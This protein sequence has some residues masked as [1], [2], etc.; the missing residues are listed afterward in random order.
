MPLSMSRTASTHT[1]VALTTQRA[2]SVAVTPLSLSRTCNPRTWPFSCT[3]PVA[4]Q[5]LTSKAPRAAAV[6]ASN[7]ARRASSNWPSQ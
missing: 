2:R 4:A 1:P 5:W 7:S 3:S 6:R